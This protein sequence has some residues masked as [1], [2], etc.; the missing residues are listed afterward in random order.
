MSAIEPAGTL[1][2]LERVIER[3]LETF[4]E[5]GEALTRIRDE[6]LYREAG[7][8]SFETYCQQRWKHRRSWADRHITAVRKLG[9]LDPTGSTPAN[10]W[11]TRQLGRPPDMVDLPMSEI[12]TAYEEGRITFGQGV[13]SIAA[14]GREAVERVNEC[15]ARLMHIAVMGRAEGWPGGQFDDDIGCGRHDSWEMFILAHCLPEPAWGS[16]QLDE[17]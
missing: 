7:Y 1:A 16:A 8:S 17:R 11:Q 5:V 12:P 9:E 10:D 4:I 14:Q 6:R 3:G 15:R 13:A 2:N